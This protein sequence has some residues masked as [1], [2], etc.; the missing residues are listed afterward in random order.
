M[1]TFKEIIG[2][3]GIVSHLQNALRTGSISHAYIL[4]GETGTGR[5]TIARTYAAALQCAS[6]TEKD[7]LLEPCGSCI[8]C[9]QLQGDNQPDII[10]V[11]KDPDRKSGPGVDLIRRMRSDIQVRPYA[12]QY[13][14]YIVEDAQQMTV[15]AQNALLKVLEEPPSYAVIMLIADGLT[16]FLPTILSRCVVLQV[17]QLRDEDVVNALLERTDADP[18]RA[19]ITARSVGGNLGRALQLCG[20]EA[21][22][23][24]RR[25]TVGLLKKLRRATAQDLRDFA[26]ELDAGARSDFLSFAAMWYRDILVCKSTGNA[27]HLIFEEEVQYIK[28]NASRLSYEA[29]SQILE[30]MDSVDRSLKANVNPEMVMQ[31]LLLRLREAERGQQ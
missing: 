12:G 5:R 27:D 28:E 23:E 13:K 6:L 29:L 21:F 15:Q 7:G 22:M 4:N 1:Y 14:I 20:D 2:Q 16:G 30:A 11:R 24:R 25:H 19:R 31:V 26:S 9:M 18:E 10:T 17:R 3:E 8:S